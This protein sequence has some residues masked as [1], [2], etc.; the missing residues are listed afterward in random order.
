MRHVFISSCSRHGAGLAAACILPN[1][2]THTL[3]RTCSF[4]FNSDRPGAGGEMS[5]DVFA[6]AMKTV[7]VTFQVREQGPGMDPGPRH[8]P[9][10]ELFLRVCLCV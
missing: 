3:L 4:A 1:T 2:H 10:A 6:S 9:S 5:R 8:G 7:D